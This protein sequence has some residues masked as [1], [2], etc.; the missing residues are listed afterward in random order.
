MQQLSNTKK[1]PNCAEIIQVSADYCRF[2]HRG[3]ST[4]DFKKCP[5][6]AEMVRK[7]ATRCRFCQ[8]DLSASS[9][10][11]GRPPDNAPVPRMP[12]NP[13][14]S[15]EIALALP[16]PEPDDLISKVLPLKKVQPPKAEE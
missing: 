3:L 16:Q 4:L 15:T 11:P 9:E 6:C 12:V 2:C 1:C 5:F 10:P 13:R 14:R 8:S 7:S